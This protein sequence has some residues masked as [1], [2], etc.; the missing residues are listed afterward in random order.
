MLRENGWLSLENSN[1]WSVPPPEKKTCGQL[2]FPF[3]ELRPDLPCNNLLLLPPKAELETKAVL[4][5]A[6]RGPC[7]NFRLTTPC[8]ACSKTVMI[9]NSV[10]R[11]PK[12]PFSWC[13]SVP[14]G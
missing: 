6:A 5:Q 4:K 2:G 13:L 9:L 1:C 12:I 7:R 3:A 8:I 11:I 14:F 10:S